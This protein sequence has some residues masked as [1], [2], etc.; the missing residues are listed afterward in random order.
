LFVDLPVIFSDPLRNPNDQGFGDMLAG[1]KLS[2]YQDFCQ[3]LTFQ[4]KNYIPTADSS[5]DWIGT[6]HYS[7]EP[8]LLY[9][10][11]LDRN[12]SL[13]AEV[14]DWISIGGAVNPDNNEDYAGN[15]IRYGVGLGYDMGRIG[16]YAVKPIVE[17]VGWSV[18]EG[19]VFEFNDLVDRSNTDLAA[20]N[21]GPVDADGDTIVNIKLGARLTNCCGGSLYAGWGHSLT[22]DRWYRD[23]F[24]FELRRMF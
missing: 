8:G 14:R 6:G 24:R 20:G 19:Q 7:I 9:Y 11:N 15:V 2:L 13:E 21:V 22:G 16:D 3:Q 18:L 12:W 5:E 1:L 23:I 10:R 4:L 17:F